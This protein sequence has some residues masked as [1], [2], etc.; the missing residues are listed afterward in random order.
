MPDLWPDNFGTEVR[1]PVAI[2]REQARHLSNRMGGVV[3][4]KVITKKDGKNPQQI[5][6]RFVLEV[7]NLDDYSYTLFYVRHP[8]VLYPLDI[9]TDLDNVSHQLD[10]QDAPHFE[11]VLAELFAH[12]QI[13]KV[14]NALKA[15]GADE[16]IPF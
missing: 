1:S 3:L 2:L 11:R 13:L 6:H 16:P 14:V 12:P 5:L 10:I 9:E 7:P 8:V 4:A 15:Q